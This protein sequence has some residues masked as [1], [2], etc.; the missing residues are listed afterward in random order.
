MEIRIGRMGYVPSEENE[1][2]NLPLGT[3]S[4]D[5]ILISNKVSYDVKPVPGA[6]DPIEMCMNV[7]TDGS[8]NPKDAIG[9]SATYIRTTQ[10][11]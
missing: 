10:V 2:P 8:I 4:I 5:S 11:Y 1:L 6:K 9:Y 3:L 7:E